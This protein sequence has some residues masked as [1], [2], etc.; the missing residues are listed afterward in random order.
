MQRKAIEW[1]AMLMRE[2]GRILKAAC[3]T[4]AIRNEIYEHST[5]CIAHYTITHYLTLSSASSARSTP[6]TLLEFFRVFGGMSL[7]MRQ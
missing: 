1:L 2:G 3:I 7:S 5:V 6:R 4:T